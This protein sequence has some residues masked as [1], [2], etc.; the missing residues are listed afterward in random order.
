MRLPT[1]SL[2]STPHQVSFMGQD[3]WLL[4]VAKDLTP[5]SPDTSNISGNISL[6]S[7][8]AGFVHANGHVSADALLPCSRCGRTQKIH[9]E[10]PISA[11]FRP[12]Y[13]EHA[14]RDLALES[15]DFEVYFIEQGQVDLEVLVNDVLQC[16]LPAQIICEEGD[17]EGCV[18]DDY[19]S[20]L[21]YGDNKPLEK[22]S[23]FAILKSLKKS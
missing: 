23:P 7:D 5:D 9:L 8:T 3:P 17:L 22:E 6:H 13:S 19:G 20:D 11:T 18:G 15:E 1:Q 16:A 4:R 10:S 21:V 14:P 2:S 12:P